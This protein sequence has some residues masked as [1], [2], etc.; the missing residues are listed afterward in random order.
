MKTI[1]RAVRQVRWILDFLVE[2]Y[3]SNAINFAYRFLADR[4]NAED[5]VQ[6]AFLRVY[7]NSA[8]FSPT[9]SFRA[10]FFPKVWR[11][12]A[13]TRARS[14]NRLIVM[15]YRKGLTAAPAP[16]RLWTGV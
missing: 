13:A 6:E 14:I 2:R 9:T 7:R 10:W 1:S 11:I 8:Q 15:S 4:G 3:Q 12:S 5:V 16:A